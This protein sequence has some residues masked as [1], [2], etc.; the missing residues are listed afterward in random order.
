FV[1]IACETIGEDEA[2][3]LFGRGDA[4]GHEAGLIA[5]AEGGTLVLDNLEELPPRLQARLVSLIAERR[6][7]PVGALRERATT[8]RV[9]VT[10]RGSAQTDSLRRDLFHRLSGYR[11]TLPALA[12]RQDMVSI[13]ARV[14][15]QA[16][17]CP[18]TFDT[19][20]A[21][22]LTRHPWHSNLHELAAMAQAIAATYAPCPASGIHL[23]LAQLPPELCDDSPDPRSDTPAMLRHVLNQHG[24]NISAVAEALG[25]DRT[26]IH[27]RMARHGLTRASKAVSRRSQ[28]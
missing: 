3:V 15:G 6:F 10:S 5:S 12:H 18:V 16:L 28:T 2:A 13:A 17:G 19:A 21:S 25:V 14:F 26:T 20:A 11:L 8:A 1:T 9:I 22:A 24:W 23:C 4:R 7:R 27:R